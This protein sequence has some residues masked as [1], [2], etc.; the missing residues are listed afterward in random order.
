MFHWAAAT[1]TAVLLIAANALAQTPAPA[2]PP[3]TPTITPK[4]S[5]TPTSTPGTAQLLDS[6]GQADL[7]AAINLL[8]TNFANPDA[9]TETELDRATLAGLLM[10]IPGALMLLPPAR[11]SAAAEA[12]APFYS[13]VLEGSVGYLRLGALTGTNLKELDK[14]LEEMKKAGALIVDLRDS[15]TGD[16]AT[17]AEFAKRFCPKGKTLF[18]LHKPPARQDRVFNSDRDPLF[19]GLSTVLIDGETAGGAEAL[20]AALRFYSKALL[21]GQPTAGRAVEYSDL[22]LPSGTILRVAAAAALG[23]TGQ[24]LFPGG[25]KPDLPVEM[26]P[27]EKRQIFR[28]SVEKGMAPFV[29]ETER[30]HLNEAALIAGTNPELDAAEAQRRA[31]RGREKQPVRDPVVQRAIDLVTS[32]EIYQKR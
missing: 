14:K 31:A 30:P 26:A 25:I 1:A 17:A 15:A 10:R 8:K 27:G 5:P 4:A 13:E 7:Q 18:S 19:Q 12:A 24:P 9:I 29:Y 23:P 6:L 20:A 28:L 32:L 16:F 11:E 3:P 22:P 21:I 2:K